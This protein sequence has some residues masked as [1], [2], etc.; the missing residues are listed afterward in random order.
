MACA[1]L[2]SVA[3]DGDRWMCSYKGY[4]EEGDYYYIVVKPFDGDASQ[5]QRL[6]SHEFAD[7]L[8]ADLAPGKRFSG[9]RACARRPRETTGQWFAK[10]LSGKHMFSTRRNAT[11]AEWQDGRLVELPWPA[12]ADQP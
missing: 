2:P 8:Y 4:T 3:S 10:V 6:N 5:H 12:P 1:A 9:E 7:A 11:L